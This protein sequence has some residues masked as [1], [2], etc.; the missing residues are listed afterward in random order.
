M[1][2]E[3]LPL[4][5]NHRVALY[6]LGGVGK[7]QTG[8][9]YSYNF[10]AEY[11]HV[12]WINAEN[13]ANLKSGFEKMLLKTGTVLTNS[14]L[15]L[16][17]LARLGRAWLNEQTRWLV[18]IDNLDEFK[19]V[20]DLLPEGDLR[21]DVLIT[22]RNAAV[23][24]IPSRGLEVPPLS[25][26]ES[27]TMLYA[28]SRRPADAEQIEAKEIVR[29]LG[30][31]PLAIAQAASYIQETRS[32]LKTFQARYQVDRKE[33]YTKRLPRGNR[34]YFHTLATTWSMSF[35]LLISQHPQSCTELLQLLS[36]LN[37]DFVVIE[38]LELGGGALPA[39]L[40]QALL[41]RPQ[42]E[43]ALIDLETYS[44]VKWHRRADGLSIHRLVQN[45]VRDQL[46]PGQLES[47]ISTVVELIHMASLR[48]IAGRSRCRFHDQ[49]VEPLFN[50]SRL[51]L[52]QRTPT[53]NSSLPYKSLRMADVLGRI[54]R[55]L[56]DDGNLRDS[57]RLLQQSLEVRL[58]IAP[59]EKPELQA[60]Y[61]DLASLVCARGH[62]DDAIKMQKKAYDSSK[63]E[64]GERSPDTLIKRNNLAVTYGNLGRFQEALDLLEKMLPITCQIFGKRYQ[65]DEGEK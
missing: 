61:T 48:K 40:Q 46:S 12:F 39:A 15:T 24:G 1:L 11:D 56:Y 21:N 45:F 47:W 25:E 62:W 28:L 17:E 30:H 3:K 44:L 19:H 10:K 42:L 13:E 65:H 37:P 26:N 20:C 23:L 52:S 38:F 18:I 43:N 33:V 32:S 31:L 50:L 2:N 4:E 41:N 64:F 58:Q 57:Q 14:G 8:L 53:E 9:V 36:F 22:T 54:G 16:E 5:Y 59:H 29:E 60:E 7:T 55:L 6:G 34:Q 35:R 51:A 63:L 27:I 49:I